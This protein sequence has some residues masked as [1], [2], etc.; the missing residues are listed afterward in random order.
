MNY[1]ILF[2]LIFMNLYI[3]CNYNTINKL[4][5]IHES[6]LYIHGKM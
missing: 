5:K 4:L 3:I 6:Q 1:T 2:I